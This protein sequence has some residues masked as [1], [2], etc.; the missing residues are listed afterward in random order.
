[1]DRADAAIDYGGLSGCDRH[2]HV[3]AGISNGWGSVALAEIAWFDLRAC[4]ER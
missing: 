4:V 2:R 1:V 3:S